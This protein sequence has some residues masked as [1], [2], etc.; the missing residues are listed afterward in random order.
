MTASRHQ[1]LQR[2]RDQLGQAA[3]ADFLTDIILADHDGRIDLV[4]LPALADAWARARPEPRFARRQ[5]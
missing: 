1:A 2:V 5:S 3:Y 4:D